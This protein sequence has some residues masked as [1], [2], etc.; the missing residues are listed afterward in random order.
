ML[1]FLG[2]HRVSALVPPGVRF[3]RLNFFIENSGYFKAVYQSS[4]YHDVFV[5]TKVRCRLASCAWTGPQSAQMW[6]RGPPAAFPSRRGAQPSACVSHARWA[7]PLACLPRGCPVIWLDVQN[8]TNVFCF[9]FKIIWEE[10]KPGSFP[11]VLLLALRRLVLGFQSLAPPGRLH[12][13]VWTLPFYPSFRP[14]S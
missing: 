5:F 8:M 12:R 3:L 6:P 14:V 4:G 1:R 13:G 9:F 10:H 2:N 11:W 7:P